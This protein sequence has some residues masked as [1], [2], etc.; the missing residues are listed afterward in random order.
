M[1]NILI[2]V[3]LLITI[4]A[5]AQNWTIITGSIHNIGD[6]TVP[7]ELMVF[8]PHKIA[9]P[10]SR[11]NQNT[12]SGQFKFII[13]L[14]Q[15]ST[16]GF[17]VNNKPLFFPGTFGTIIN[18]GDSLNIEI[19]DVK[20]LGFTDLQYSGRGSEKQNLQ[21]EMITKIVELAKLDPPYDKRSLEYK[22]SSTDRK[23][24]RL[25]SVYQ[26]YKGDISLESKNLMLA[27]EYD[28]IL[29][30]LTVSA[31]RSTD[32]LLKPYIQKYII[33]KKRLEP[34]FR[35]NA[36]YYGGGSS[37]VP[38]LLILMSYD[39]IAQYG[40]QNFRVDN[41]L[42]FVEAVLKYFKK[43]PLQRDYF[44][45][46]TAINVFDREF[47]SEN[48]RKI[49]AI[50]KK[51]ADKRNPFYDQVLKA[52]EKIESHLKNGMPFYNFQLPD[53]TGK[54]HSLQ[55]FRGQLLVFDFWFR[56]CGACK[57]MVPKLNELEE[58]YR[59]KN[60]KFI[61]ISVDED[62][63]DWL[64]GI[65]TFSSKKSLQLYTNGLVLKHPLLQFLGISGFPF[66]IVVDDRGSIIGIPPDPSGNKRD[67]ENFID[68]YLRIN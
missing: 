38:Y 17:T 8:D 58:K 37:V 40:G 2:I 35:G 61:S 52:N 27:H 32:S 42:M 63:K 28:D 51:D 24:D 19:S 16:I 23:L 36:I 4:K 45:S 11:Y 9:V 64:K 15:S 3:L 5:T 47:D 34:F 67:F 20:K 43:Q 60:V 25:D 1:K 44:L 48:S 33:E 54:L 12:S 13:N 6:K 56:G 21:K 50:Y 57:M 10:F 22:F 41:P 62:K 53:T 59:D 26:H 66:L 55:D 7:V 68:R 39:N 46:Q 31:M 49:Y 29:E 65:G 18:P 14:S 30:S